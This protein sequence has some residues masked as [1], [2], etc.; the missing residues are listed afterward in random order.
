MT[1]MQGFEVEEL[2]FTAEGDPADPPRVEA[3]LRQIE[4]RAP[5]DL[6]VLAHGWNND[7]A[8]ARD[9]YEA[10]LGVIRTAADRRGWTEDARRI[11]VLEVLWPS[12]QFADADLIAGGAAGVRHAADPDDVA[13]L[14]AQIDLL[15]GLASDAEIEELRE[16]SPRLPTDAAA[17]DRFVAITLKLL[18]DTARDDGD[19]G[20]EVP[21]DLSPDRNDGSLLPALQLEPVDER[22]GTGAAEGGAAV[23]GR[24]GLTH[25]DG[26]AAGVGD[27]V[28]GAV[29]GARNLLNYLTYYKMKNRAGIVGRR[30]V[31]PLLARIASLP[32]PPRVH[33]VGHSFGA[34]VVTAAVLGP[35]GGASNQVNTLVLVQAAFS[36]NSFAEDFQG[37]RDGFFRAIVAPTRCVSG[38]IMITHTDNDKAVGVAYAIASRVAGQDASAVGGADDRYGGL[39]RNGA[40]YTPE[41]FSTEM[42]DTGNDY[43]ALDQHAVY[44]L[45]ADEY[46]GSHSKVRGPQVGEVIVQAMA[47]TAPAP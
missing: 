5:S 37:T 18:E 35:E 31:A 32:Q 33:L 23:L 10:W 47:V 3:F 7:M 6:L 26:G 43:D 44:N 21:A 19:S 1:Q 34:R 24:G 30:G 20:S 25:D 28:R 11:D 46:I 36:H 22:S 27:W 45:L 14:A 38:P 15:D 17:R 8:Q 13:A 29:E 16:L 4:E 2:E 39:G 9:L 41:A 12:K 40:V 42:L